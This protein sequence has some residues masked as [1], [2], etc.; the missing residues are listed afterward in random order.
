MKVE[1]GDQVVL[2]SDGFA[3]QFGGPFGK[4]MKYK[5]F[6]D[7]LVSVSGKTMKEQQEFMTR[8]FEEWKKNFDQVDDVCVVAV[9]L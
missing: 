1:K 5:P 4:K 7:L 9:K 2:F 8:S 3:D 6:K